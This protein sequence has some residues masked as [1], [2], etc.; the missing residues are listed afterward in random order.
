MAEYL[1]KPETLTLPLYSPRTPTRGRERVLKLARYWRYPQISPPYGMAYLAADYAWWTDVPKKQEDLEPPE[2]E[3]IGKLVL[4]LQPRTTK[5]PYEQ[6][7]LYMPLDGN[8]AKQEHWTLLNRSIRFVWWA[9][10]PHYPK[11]PHLSMERS[12][13]HDE[14]NRLIR[15]GKLPPEPVSGNPSQ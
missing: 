8:E 10:L 7:V 1:T 3:P 5:S 13:K 2:D 9:Q 4:T 12:K 6:R 11:A 14:V 15:E